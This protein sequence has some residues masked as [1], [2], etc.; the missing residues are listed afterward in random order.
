MIKL[1]KEEIQFWINERFG[2]PNTF[3]TQLLTDFQ[4]YLYNNQDKTL[5]DI[6]KRGG[7]K[8]VTPKNTQQE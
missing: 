3:N 2:I 1:T 6:A 8:W 7:F 5:A 4:D